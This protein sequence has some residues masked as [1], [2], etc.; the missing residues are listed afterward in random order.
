MRNEQMSRAKMLEWINMYSFAK[1]DA[2][3]YLD[4]HPMDVNALE[5]FNKYSRLRNEA[6]EEY[7]RLY[8]PLTVDTADINNQKWEWIDEPW[9]WEGK[10]GC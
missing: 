6:L 1:D 4:T 10:E 5:Y 3:L 7:A 9:P 8:G 2:V